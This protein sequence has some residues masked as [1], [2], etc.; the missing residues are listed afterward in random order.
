MKK[1]IFVSLAL[2]LGPVFAAWG[3]DEYGGMRIESAQAEENAIRVSSIGAEFLFNLPTGGIDLI[4]RIP[5]RRQVGSIVGLDLKGAEFKLEEG[6]C[7]ITVPGSGTVFT[8]T[9]DSLLRINF[10]SSASVEVQGRYTPV[11][12]VTTTNCFFLPDESGG[13][14]LYAFGPVTSRA[15]GNW[16]AP[17]S[18]PFQVNASGQLWVSVFPPRPFDWAQSREGML[19]SFSWK[20]PYP[21]DEQLQQWR[22]FGSVLTLHSWI[23]QG[24]NGRNARVEKDDSWLARDFRPKSDEELARVIQTAHRLKMKVIPYMS[25]FYQ[26]DPTPAGRE[27]FVKQIEVAR[28]TYGFDGVYFDGIYSDIPASYELVRRARKVIGKEGILHIHVTFVPAISCPFIECYADYTLRGE[29][30]RLSNDYTR[31]TI[32]GWNMSNSIGMTCYDRT[33]PS[34]TL[35]ETMLAAHARLPIWVD[36]GTWNGASYHLSAP[37]LKLMEDEYLPRLGAQTGRGS[38][39]GSGGEKSAR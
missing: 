38:G 8:I 30:A 4:Q 27:R 9:A 39:E 11:K 18:I 17:W 23:W 7:R 14:G 26:S 13:I 29:H 36:D 25:A 20:N 33:R 24:T 15:P 21:S 3:G 32:S 10:A 31:W 2:C 35:I 6:Q 12:K 22:K 19:H 1:Q 5:Q 16:Q 28:Q 34:T 37:E